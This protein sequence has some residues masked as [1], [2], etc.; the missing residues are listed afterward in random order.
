MCRIYLLADI[1]IKVHARPSSI[2]SCLPASVSIIK[3]IIKEESQ[4]I[5]ISFIP[6]IGARRFQDFMKILKE[7]ATENSEALN[8]D[9]NKGLLHMFDERKSV[10]KAALGLLIYS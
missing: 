9:T 5:A 7:I 4:K 10:E 1:E 8:I 2:L 6:S 3:Q